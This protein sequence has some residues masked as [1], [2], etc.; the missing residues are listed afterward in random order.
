MGQ[1]FT[2]NKKWV[3]KIVCMLYIFPYDADTIMFHSLYSSLQSGR[4]L[5]RGI[6]AVWKVL[7]QSNI[8]PRSKE[9]LQTIII[10]YKQ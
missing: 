2:A 4:I 1:R 6:S 9:I 7:L 8:K 5:V 10:P 3:S